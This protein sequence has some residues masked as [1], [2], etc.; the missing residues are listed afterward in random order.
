VFTVPITT[1]YYREDLDPTQTPSERRLR[2]G[3]E[4]HMRA[5][6]RHDF[7]EQLRR[8]FKRE[9]H[10]SQIVQITEGALQ[11]AVVPVSVLT[12]ITSHTVFVWRKSSD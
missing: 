7:G 5:F 1:N 12:E 3:Q 8:L 10:F 2:F 6:G 11:R 9:V 4:D